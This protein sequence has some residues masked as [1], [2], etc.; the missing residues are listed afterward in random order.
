MSRHLTFFFTGSISPD[1]DIAHDNITL[2]SGMQEMLDLIQDIEDKFGIDV[3]IGGISTFIGK[4][5]RYGKTEKTPYGK[6][7]KY[8]LAG[9]LQKGLK[10]YKPKKSQWDEIAIIS[11]I[12]KIP[13]KIIIYLY[14]N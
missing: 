1:T 2:N 7:M 11:Y 13:K 12:K 9:D 5:M 14:W 3:K 8:V 4:G 10:K 6:R